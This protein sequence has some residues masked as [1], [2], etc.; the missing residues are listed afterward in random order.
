MDY[1][2]VYFGISRK[3]VCN[4]EKATVASY[5][6][7][8]SKF[9]LAA[10]IMFYEISAIGNCAELPKLAPRNPQ[11]RLQKQQNHH[12]Q[13]LPS[14]TTSCPSPLHPP[15]RARDSSLERPRCKHSLQQSP[16]KIH[17]VKA[18]LQI[19]DLSGHRRVK[20]VYFQQLLML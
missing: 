1:P 7:G 10:A 9:L 4:Q 20:W 3:F 18:K 14:P 12:F 15:Q 6:N 8:N 5:I 19:P 2:F 11:A 13:H 17:R 16:V